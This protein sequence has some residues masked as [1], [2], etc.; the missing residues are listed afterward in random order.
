M[1]TYNFVLALATL[2]AAAGKTT[3]LR[4]AEANDLSASDTPPCSLGTASINQ[5]T[6]EKP[7]CAFDVAS[8]NRGDV[9]IELPGG[10]VS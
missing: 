3:N 9:Q 2:S 4:K 8:L 5:Q 1:K 7:Q 10:K 6:I